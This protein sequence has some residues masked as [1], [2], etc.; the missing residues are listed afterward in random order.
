MSSREKR[1]QNFLNDGICRVPLEAP[2]PNEASPSSNALVRE[3]LR[4]RDAGEL[5]GG[6][7]GS[8]PARLGDRLL[9]R[10]WAF[11]LPIRLRKRPPP[12]QRLGESSKSS[13]V[14]SPEAA[15][16]GLPESATNSSVSEMKSGEHKCSRWTARLKL[17]FAAELSNAARRGDGLSPR[18]M[19][20]LREGMAQAGV[21]FGIAVLDSTAFSWRYM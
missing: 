12:V 16:C 18:M 21:V 5:V 19:M 4:G 14:E 1:K 2:S 11:E 6:R 17:A 7:G 3:P 10:E 8:C 13:S 15:V 20:N 9:D